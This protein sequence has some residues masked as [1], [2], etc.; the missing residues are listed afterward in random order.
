VSGVWADRADPAA[1]IHQNQAPVILNMFAKASF[2]RPFS[3]PVIKRRVLKGDIVLIEIKEV[4]AFRGRHLPNRFQD[5]Y[6]I[7]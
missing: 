2:D 1:Y 5:I 6:I 3:V 4:K 7:T